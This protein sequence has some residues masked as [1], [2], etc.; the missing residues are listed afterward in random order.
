MKKE[1][2]KVMEASGSP[3]QACARR[4]MAHVLYL[5]QEIGPRGSC[6]AGERQAA[7]YAAE[8]MRAAGAA[9]VRLEPFRGA[10]STYRPYALAFVAALLGALLVWLAGGRWSLAAAALLSALGAWG[11]WAETDLAGNWLRWLLPRATSQNAVG[12]VAP[13]GEVRRRVVLCAHL[14]T[15]RTPVFYSSQRWHTLF[16]LLVAGAFVGLVLGAVLYGLGALWGWDWARWPGLAAVA[17]QVLAL[18]LCLHAEATPFSPG[19]NDNATGAGVA[20]ALAE[21]LARQPLAHTET[22][23]AFTGCE[24]V[25][26]YGMIDFLDHHAADLGPET[27]YVIADQ[28]GA[29]RLIYLTADGL[30]RKRKT[31]PRA[32]ALARRAEAA[33]PGL[34]IVER[35]GIAYTDALVATRRGLVALTLCA[36]PRPGEGQGSHWHQMS[37]T[38]EHLDEAALTDACA[39]VW[40][41]L[42]EVDGGS[43]S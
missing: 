16:G 36:L 25:G 18:A 32:L 12:V 34:E 24:E 10:P 43:Q 29:G 19:A 20:L 3:D 2:E 17:V 11:M 42:Q 7:V 26:A 13:A 21:R 9:G 4:A 31:H 14:D 38:A 40:Q 8:Q 37:D 1:G 39:F 6:T 15:H 30:I 35:V 28:V 5:S 23:L 22:W 33:L 27:V 41:I